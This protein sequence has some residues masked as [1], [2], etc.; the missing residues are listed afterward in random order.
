MREQLS[1]LAAPAE[2]RRSAE[3]SLCLKY[4]YSLAREWAAGTRCLFVMLNPSTADAFAD[5]PTIRRCIGFARA[6]GHGALEVVNLFALRSTDPAALRTA[7]DPVGPNNDAILLEAARR[8]DLVVAAWG[9]D[10]MARARAAR[11]TAL[12]TRHHAMHCLVKNADGSPK[13]PLY[14]AADTALVPF[15]EKQAVRRG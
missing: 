14:V 1:M 12:V 15:A 9:K 10:P 5:D 8:A 6:W 4:R 3:I 7:A 13:H 11:V 2:M